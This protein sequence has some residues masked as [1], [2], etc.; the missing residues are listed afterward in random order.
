[1]IQINSIQVPAGAIKRLFLFANQLIYSSISVDP[2]PTCA[3]IDRTEMFCNHYVVAAIQRSGEG[4][5]QAMYLYT[6]VLWG[7]LT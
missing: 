3:R 7:L 1:M 2:R 4:N 6:L 5:K